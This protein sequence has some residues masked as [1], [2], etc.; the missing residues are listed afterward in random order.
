MVAW[1][2][3]PVVL[4]VTALANTL[5]VLLRVMSASLALVVKEE[6]PVT[7]TA[8]PWVMFP[9]VAV[10]LKLP[11]TARSGFASMNRSPLVPADE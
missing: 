4:R 6:V 11:P 5:P 10:M 7:A 2:V 3:E 1:P 8:A 9:V